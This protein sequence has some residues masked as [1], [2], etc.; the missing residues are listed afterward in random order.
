MMPRRKPPAEQVAVAREID[1]VA[2]GGEDL[3]GALRHVQAGVGERDLA[4]PPLDQFG[5]DLALQLAH[6][7]RQRRLGHRAVRRRPP[8]MP[9]ARERGEI[10]QLPQGDHS[11]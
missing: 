10:T 8:E 11:R 3:L 4:R 1:Q 5:A 9:V 2:G 6:L 7:H